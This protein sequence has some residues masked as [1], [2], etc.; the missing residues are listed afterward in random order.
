MADFPIEPELAVRDGPRLRSIGQATEFVRSMVDARSFNPWKDLLRRLE[1]VRTQ[2]EALEAAGALREMLEL[3]HMLA[4]Q[5]D[6]EHARMQGHDFP[7]VPALRVGGAPP[8][9]LRSTEEAAI[10]LR[11]LIA[12]RP[13]PHWAATLRKIE[14][15]RSQAEAADAADEVRAI[16]K[17]EHLLID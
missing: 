3:E 17:S 11:E 4:P 2:E 14:R 15:I 10:F 8:R 7:L 16:L 12:Q 1:A 13:D 9:V 5:K 6:P